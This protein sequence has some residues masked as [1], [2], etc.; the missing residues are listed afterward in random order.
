MFQRFVIRFRDIFRFST[1][2]VDEGTGFSCRI[3]GHKRK[4]HITTPSTVATTTTTT[5]APIKCPSLDEAFCE[6]GRVKN[7]SNL[8][9]SR[10]N[11]PIDSSFDF[12]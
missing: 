4:A 10:M 9:F 6:C 5:L 2:S 7:I 3:L 12:K 1:N 8:D 11:N